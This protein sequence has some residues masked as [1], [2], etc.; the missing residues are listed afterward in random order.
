MRWRCG[1]CK[2][3]FDLEVIDYGETNDDA[4]ALL[5]CPLCGCSDE[6]EE[7]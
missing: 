1:N 7:M 4:W 3:V 5:F 2:G 6:L